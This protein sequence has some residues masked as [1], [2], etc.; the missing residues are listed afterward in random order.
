[1]QVRKC[2][3]ISM[4]LS[5]RAYLTEQNVNLMLSPAAESFG[6]RAAERTVWPSPLHQQPQQLWTGEFTLLLF[7]VAILQIFVSFRPILCRILQLVVVWTVPWHV[8]QLLYINS[9]TFLADGTWVLAALCLTAL[10]LT[11]HVSSWPP[12]YTVLS[13]TLLA[14]CPFP[15]CVSVA[16]LLFG[17][18][19]S[20]MNPG[21]VPALFDQDF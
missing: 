19:L 1:M 4:F 17:P 18:W 7:V 16:I 10:N 13:Q 8:P 3:I 15:V 9:C 5:P 21:L 14:P 20:V 11:D 12:V 2:I 6:F